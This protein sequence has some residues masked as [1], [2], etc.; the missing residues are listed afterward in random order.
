MPK[1]SPEKRHWNGAAL[2]L[3]GALLASFS[4]LFAQHPLSLAR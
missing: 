3:A 2:A 1:V 4:K